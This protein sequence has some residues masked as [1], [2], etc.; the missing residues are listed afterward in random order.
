[1]QRTD[2]LKKTLMLGKTEGK[3]RRGRQRWDGW[4][5]SPTSWTWVWA[6]F[7]SWW[8]TG[9]PG[10]LQSMGGKESDRTEGMNWLTCLLRS[11]PGGAKEPACQCRRCKR[12]GFDLWVG[13]MPWRRKWQPTPIF[14]SGESHGERSLVGYSPWDH[15]ELDT[16]EWL[17]TCLLRW[18]AFC[19]WNVYLSK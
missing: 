9:K 12:R 7:G 8:W 3:R 1:M 13:K 15:K 4:L 16:A 10:V 18:T 2:S 11:F 14:L 19:L 5:A 17:R 6:S